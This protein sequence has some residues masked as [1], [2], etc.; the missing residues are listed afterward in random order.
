MRRI[1]IFMLMVCGLAA[2]ARDNAG[3]QSD[4]GSEEDVAAEFRQRAQDGD[5]E[6]M[7]YLGYL[8]LSGAEGVERDA[9][10]GLSWLVKAASA[11][12]VK[13]ASNLGW[14]FLEGDLVEKD[15][16]EGAR[17][18]ARAADAGLPVA[19]SLLG[20]LYLD[21]RGVAPDTV[22]ADSLYRQAFE[23]GLGD[24]GYK[25]FA[26]NKNRYEEMTPGEQV[27]AGKYFYLRGA[28]S[29]G[30]KLF[31]MAADAG[32]PDGLALLGDA[33]SRAVGVP[34]DYDLSMKY[35]V[36]AALAGNPSA[37]FV[38]GELLEIFP[39]A[40]REFDGQEGVS[41]DPR[42]WFDKAAEGGVGDAETASSLLLQ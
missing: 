5:P 26:L 33:Y 35:F 28:P 11:G 1:W 20:D 29:E 4:V 42:F 19:L 14:L 31:Y 27:E 30:V 12:S 41:D 39:D 22:A 18:I 32:S 8:L 23:R 6:A 17:W 36:E 2:A 10:E 40:L 21:G 37:Q 38:I 16:V 9:A 15:E 25:L 24:A 7:N 13:A 34:Y 3:E